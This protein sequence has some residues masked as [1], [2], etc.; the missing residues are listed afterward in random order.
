MSGSLRKRSRDY[1]V[2]RKTQRK[3]R[4]SSAKRTKT[5]DEAHQNLKSTRNFR[6]FNLDEED[7]AAENNVIVI[8]EDD[9][10]V[11]NS[12]NQ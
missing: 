11:K 10:E 2:G 7:D 6:E 3:H 12:V 8:E 9:E 1:F 4:S 5:A